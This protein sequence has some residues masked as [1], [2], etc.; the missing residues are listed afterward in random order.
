MHNNS[1]S[2][3]IEIVKGAGGALVYINILLKS[4]AN[5]LFISVGVSSNGPCF[6][7]VPSSGTTVVIFD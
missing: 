4:M 5:R 7:I 6:G 2:I 3:S 1:I